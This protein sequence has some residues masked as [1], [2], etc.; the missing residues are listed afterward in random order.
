[1]GRGYETI[2]N[3]YD[4]DDMETTVDIDVEQIREAYRSGDYH[5]LAGDLRQN[6][7]PSYC[8]DDMSVEDTE[9]Q[10]SDYGDVQV[11]HDNLETWVVNYIEENYPDDMED[12]DD[13]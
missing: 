10:D 1:M 7:D 13:D 9:Y 8:I 3:M 5:R 2:Q 11:S 6:L 4:F 12:V